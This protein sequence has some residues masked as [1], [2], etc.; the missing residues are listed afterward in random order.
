MSREEDLIQQIKDD[1]AYLWDKLGVKGVNK[2]TLAK[3][4]RKNGKKE[5]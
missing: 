1:L 2:S 5:G 3:N 4:K